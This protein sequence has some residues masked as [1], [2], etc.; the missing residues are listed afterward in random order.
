MFQAIL[1]AGPPGCGKSSQAHL[2]SQTFAIPHIDSSSLFAQTDEYTLSAKKRHADNRA[3]ARA[4][5]ADFFSDA[6]ATELLLHALTQASAPLVLL[7]GTHRTPQQV[8]LLRDVVKL[9]CVFNLTSSLS[10]EE[11]IAFLF[12]R[13]NS[14]NDRL[15]ESDTDKKLFSVRFRRYLENDLPALALL[16]VETIVPVSYEDSF[17]Q[18]QQLLVRKVEILLNK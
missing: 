4:G 7:T 10:Y 2:L 6:L 11:Q 1:L 3:D 13:L 5:S 12:A 16:P 15:R 9:V 18:I 8:H 17:S 14:A